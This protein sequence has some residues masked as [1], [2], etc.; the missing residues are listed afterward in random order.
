MCSA[1]NQGS[2]LR[3]IPRGRMSGN[4]G[5]LNRTTQHCLEVYS[6]GSENLRFLPGIDLSATQLCP[7]PIGLAGQVCSFTPLQRFRGARR[8]RLRHVST[9]VLS[10][11]CDR[12]CY[13][14]QRGKEMRKKAFLSLAANPLWPIRPWIHH[15]WPRQTSDGRPQVKHS[16][17]QRFSPNQGTPCKNAYISR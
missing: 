11:R 6:R 5:G 15:V 17:Y 14:R 12:R 2:G 9:T 4:P 3:R 13:R 8:Y 7:D 1:S 16:G 10:G